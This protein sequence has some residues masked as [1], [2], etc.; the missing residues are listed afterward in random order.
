MNEKLQSISIKLILTIP[1]LV[2]GIVT[3]LLFILKPVIELWTEKKF[4]Q[5]PIP[6]EVS[7]PEPNHT[8]M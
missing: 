3:A 5:K 2:V 7:K 6:L 1:A 4:N 8:F